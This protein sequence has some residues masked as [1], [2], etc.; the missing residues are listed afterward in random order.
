MFFLE[1]FFEICFCLEVFRCFL[2]AYKRYPD[3]PSALK[4]GYCFTMVWRTYTV[5]K[6]ILRVHK[7]L[8]G[9]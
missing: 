6:D 7:A 8:K 4:D 9:T 3:L 2:K 1:F 5:L